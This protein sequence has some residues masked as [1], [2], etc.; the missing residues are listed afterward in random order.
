MIHLLY[1]AHV[2]KKNLLDFLN[3]FD[4]T[5]GWCHKNG[6]VVTAGAEQVEWYQIHQILGFPLVPAIVMSRPPL[7]SLLYHLGYLTSLADGNNINNKPLGLGQ[8]LEN[9]TRG[10][11]SVGQGS[12][13]YLLPVHSNQRPRHVLYHYRHLQ[14]HQHNLTN[15]FNKLLVMTTSAPLFKLKRSWHHG[16]SKRREGEKTW[17]KVK[18]IWIQGRPIVKA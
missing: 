11:Q 16:R 1:L 5:G 12:Y 7:S 3:W 14:K 10:S 13:I 9:C 2:T 17:F 8:T 15:V 6:L 4:Y 18:E